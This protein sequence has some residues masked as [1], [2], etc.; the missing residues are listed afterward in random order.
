MVVGTWL[1]AE[2]MSNWSRRHLLE[3]IASEGRQA[4]L[5]SARE[6]SGLLEAAGFSEIRVEDLT[7]QVKRTWIV[8]IRR[9]LVRL[10]TRPRYWRLLLNASASD[11]IFAV[12]SCRILAA[13]QIGCMRYALFTCK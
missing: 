13:Y 11:R 6:L 5:V 3:P 12:T 7:L 1:A 8:V 4:A 10:L 9:M 2:T